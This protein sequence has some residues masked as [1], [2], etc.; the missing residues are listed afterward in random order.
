MAFNIEMSIVFKTMISSEYNKGAL[1]SV[2][3]RSGKDI[4][5]KVPV[6]SDSFLEPR[7]AI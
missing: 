7:I 2:R 5:G 6:V 3:E 1:H 4:A